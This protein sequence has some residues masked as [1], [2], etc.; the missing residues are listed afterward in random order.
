M[1][2]TFCKYAFI[3]LATFVFSSASL[4][5]GQEEAG[6]YT[7]L[8]VGDR[9]FLL[10]TKTG[11]CFRYYFNKV[12]DQG[13]SPTIIYLGSWDEKNHYKTSPSEKTISLSHSKS[14]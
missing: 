6:T 13:W 7:I 1:N 14:E 8:E 3:A 5:A 4:L 12:D 9:T 2:L 10:D 11:E